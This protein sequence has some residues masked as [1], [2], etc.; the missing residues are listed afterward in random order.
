[1]RK[2]R[3]AVVIAAVVTVGAAAIATS[4]SAEARCW[5]CWTGAGASAYAYGPYFSYP[6]YNGYGGSPL[7]ITESLRQLTIMLAFM[8]RG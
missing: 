5:G 7:S 6:A 4:K 8:P 2:S 3:T 1:V